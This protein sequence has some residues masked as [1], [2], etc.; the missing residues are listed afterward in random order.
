[1]DTTI[2]TSRIANTILIKCSGVEFSLGVLLT[3]CTIFEKFLACIC[4]VPELNRSSCHSDKFQIIGFLGPLNVGNGVSTSRKREEHLFSLDV[5]DIHIVVIT[6]INAGN[7][8]LARTDWKSGTTLGLW[9]QRKL[10]DRH[11]S[12]CVPYMNS[13]KFTTFASCNNVSKFSSGNV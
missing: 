5:V 3:K 4:W 1:M 2:G 10:S 8:S 11:H 7:I 9:T 13:W 6:L 12:Q